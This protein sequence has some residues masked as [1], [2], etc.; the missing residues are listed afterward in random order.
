MR[1]FLLSNGEQRGGLGPCAS[2][3]GVAK[4]SAALSTDTN[5]NHASTDQGMDEVI[6]LVRRALAQLDAMKAPPE[7]GARLQEVLDLMVENRT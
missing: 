5:G 3:L 2:M 6:A 1:L 7:F 4:M